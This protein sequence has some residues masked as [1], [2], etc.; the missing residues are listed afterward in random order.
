VAGI[1]PFHLELVAR[2]K[3]LVLEMLFLSMAGSF[4]G[5][6]RSDTRFLELLMVSASNLS[7][8]ATTAMTAVGVGAPGE[9]WKF[10]AIE[11]RKPSIR[12]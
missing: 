11:G 10:W 4:R 6:C 9:E 5:V 2:R 12:M 1:D 7:G 8:L 3:A